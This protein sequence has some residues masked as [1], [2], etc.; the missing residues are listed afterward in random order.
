VQK[1]SR[2]LLALPGTDRF[3]SCEALA[4]P[5]GLAVSI[6]TNALANTTAPTLQAALGAR[7]S[8]WGYAPQAD[9]ALAKCIVKG[10]PPVEIPQKLDAN[11][12]P[13]Q[14]FGNAIQSPDSAE[15]RTI[16]QTC[17]DAFRAAHLASSPVRP[18]RC[19]AAPFHHAGLEHLRRRRIQKAEPRR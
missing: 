13:L 4:R 10:I 11:G 1:L 15:L 9:P 14:D 18:V 7:W 17:R 5:V 12:Q 2:R 3:V 6:G 19:D 16:R 8:L